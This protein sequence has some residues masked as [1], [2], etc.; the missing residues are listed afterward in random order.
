MIKM[1][2]MKDLAATTYL[3]SSG[4]FTPVSRKDTWTI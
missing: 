4:I 3:F 1:E 2:F